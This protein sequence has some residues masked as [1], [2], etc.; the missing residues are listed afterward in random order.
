MSL[1]TGKHKNLDVYLY[2]IT[3][4]KRTHKSPTLSELYL[5]DYTVTRIEVMFSNVNALK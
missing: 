4:Q 1:C 3:F 2:F 5:Y